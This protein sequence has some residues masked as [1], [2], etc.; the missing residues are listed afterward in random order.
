MVWQA[1][2]DGGEM[3]IH[4][5]VECLGNGGVVFGHVDAFADIF[6]QVVEIHRTGAFPETEELVVT[7]NHRRM[8][9]GVAVVRLV[10]VKTALGESFRKIA[11]E[12]WPPAADPR[13]P[14]VTRSVFSAMPDSWAHR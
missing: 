12:K 11:P 14:A 6:V 5:P 8:Q 1:G 10:K 3:A 9:G 2:V 4:L 13:K 7:P